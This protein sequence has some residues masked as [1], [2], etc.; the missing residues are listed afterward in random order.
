MRILETFTS[1]DSII[2][3]VD[4]SVNRP[5]IF[6]FVQKSF[7]SLVKQNY[8]KTMRCFL[9]SRLPEHAYE[10]ETTSPHNEVSRIALDMINRPLNLVS[11]VE[12]ESMQRIVMSYFI[13][14][15]LLDDFDT[16]TSNFIV[17]CL[18]INPHFPYAL[19]LKTISAALD[20]SHATQHAIEKQLAE[21]VKKKGFNVYLLFAVIKLSINKFDEISVQNCANEY[22]YVLGRLLDFAVKKG[23]FKD[24][25]KVK[26]SHGSSDSD[27]DYEEDMEVDEDQ[28]TQMEN[29]ILRQATNLLNESDHPEKFIKLIEQILCGNHA[30]RS[31][32][33][34]IYNMIILQRSSPVENRIIGLISYKPEVLRTLWYNLLTASTKEDRLYISILSKGMSLGEKFHFVIKFSYF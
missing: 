16:T 26:N 32:C 10:L 28:T 12:S 33:L 22:F 31:F 19:F 5:A 14:E 11:A 2:K 13:S 20:G 21:D 18:A 4:P 6:K 25:F 34:V 7:T 29:A 3:C 24:E 15:I 30:V 9:E 8:F 27:S 23:N 17:P 1:T